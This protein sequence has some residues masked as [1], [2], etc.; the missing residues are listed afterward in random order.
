MEKMKLFLVTIC[1][2]LIS[3]IAKSQTGN[4]A[5]CLDGLDNNPCIGMDII[6]NQWT[7]EA[8]IKGNGKPWK[9]REAI[10]GTGE[11]GEI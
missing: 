6:K 9:N 2:I 1:F 11:Y 4:Y 7:L 5:L 3:G 8:W 10:I